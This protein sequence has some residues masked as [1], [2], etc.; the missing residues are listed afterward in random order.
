MWY[1]VPVI[2]ALFWCIMLIMQSRFFWVVLFI[3]GY[4]MTP[5]QRQEHMD[6][7]WLSLSKFTI[8]WLILSFIILI[9]WMAMLD[10]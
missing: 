7:F 9:V 8:Y 5:S 2:V 3:I 1:I 6:R 4:E 10:I